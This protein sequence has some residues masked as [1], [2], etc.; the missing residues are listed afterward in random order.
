MTMNRFGF[1][2]LET[3]IAVTVVTLAVAAP[4][5]AASRS[6]VAIHLAQNQMI[7]SYLAQEGI[8]YVRRMR[9]DEYLTAFRNGGANVSSAAWTAF[10]SGGDSASLSGCRSSVCMVDPTRSMGTGSGLSI[11]PC[12]GA[13]CTPLYI[14]P[15]GLYTE[16]NN[17]AGSSITPF[18]RTIQLIDLTATD[19]GV[20][21]QVTFNFHG[22]TYTIRVID[23][24]TPWQ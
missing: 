23:H 24:L 4:L 2:L 5:F 12:S 15:S 7:A 13:S 10:L 21:S 9:D 14:M 1:T 19:E 22:I 8:E 20:V 11:Q 18:T 6:T 16:Q 3:L 17:I